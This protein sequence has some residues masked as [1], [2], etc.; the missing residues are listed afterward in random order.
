MKVST[1][2]EDGVT[3]FT[4]NP[5][6]SYWLPPT[7]INRFTSLF[8]IFSG[9]KSIF[10]GLFSRKLTKKNPLWLF[11]LVVKSLERDNLSYSAHIAQK[12]ILSILKVNILYKRI[13][14][15]GILKKRFNKPARL[16]TNHFVRLNF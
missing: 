4:T 11:G 10:P 7:P 8:C 6:A 5:P 14:P 3:S 9:P 16:G 2:C 15:G 13:R 12:S 1:S